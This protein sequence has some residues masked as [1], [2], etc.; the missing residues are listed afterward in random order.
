L[1]PSWR[2]QFYCRAQKNILL[3]F[4]GTYHR[5]AVDTVARG[6]NPGYGLGW[7]NGLG[8]RAFKSL[9][10]YSTIAD[11]VKTSFEQCGPHFDNCCYYEGQAVILSHRASAVTWPNAI[12][13]GAIRKI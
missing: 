6:Y 9:K 12:I 2:P 5:L 3:A 4:V 10:R 8:W 7:R 13:S 1:A 11:D